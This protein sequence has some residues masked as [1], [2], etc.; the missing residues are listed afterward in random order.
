MLAS[1]PSLFSE[2]HSLLH[3][4][5]ICSKHTRLNSLPT[6]ASL[7]DFSVY[8]VLKSALNKHNPWHG[9]KQFRE[10]KGGPETLVL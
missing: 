5:P 4:V 10:Y 1:A 3:F 8:R 7:A 9:G 2:H 6:A